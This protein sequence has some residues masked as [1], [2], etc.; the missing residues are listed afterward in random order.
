M[1]PR[2]LSQC[3]VKR[4]LLRAGWLTQAARL[5]P[6]LPDSMLASGSRQKPWRSTEPLQ[7]RS[8]LGRQEA[9]A[10]W[11]LRPRPP[12]AALPRHSSQLPE[13]ISSH[14]PPSLCPSQFLLLILVCPFLS[15]YGIK[16]DWGIPGPLPSG[17]R[18]GSGLSSE[19]ACGDQTLHSCVRKGNQMRHLVLASSTFQAPASRPCRQASFCKWLLSNFS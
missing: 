5:C 1:S 8:S 4:G 2:G 18:L 15:L 13:A 11:T 3:G 19:P 16:K 12:H 6:P 14:Q 7:G 9:P 10:L 17:T